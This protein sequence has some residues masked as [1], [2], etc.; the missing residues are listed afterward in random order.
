MSCADSFLSWKSFSFGAAISDLKMVITSHFR[1]AIKQE[2]LENLGQWKFTEATN[3]EWNKQ[4]LSWPV[5]ADGLINEVKLSHIQLFSSGDIV[6]IYLVLVQSGPGCK[7]KF[8]PGPTLKNQENTDLMNKIQTRTRF[9]KW[10][11]S[12]PGPTVLTAVIK[13]GTGLIIDEI[14][15]QNRL[16]WYISLLEQPT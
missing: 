1:F 5:R 16:D 4:A 14:W 12:G 9:Q 6:K 11:K 13:S 15:I 3:P 2:R 7:H 10:I 8:G